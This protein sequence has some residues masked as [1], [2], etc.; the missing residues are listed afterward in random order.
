[1]LMSGR[2]GD[3]VKVTTDDTWTNTQVRGRFGWFYRNDRTGE[4]AEEISGA[5][6]VDLCPES[7]EIALSAGLVG[8]N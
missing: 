1:M 4:M 7:K 2:T 8:V 5:Y 3:P 6:L